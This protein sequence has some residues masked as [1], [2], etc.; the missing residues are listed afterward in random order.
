MQESLLEAVS[1]GRKQEES[2]KKVADVALLWQRS[3]T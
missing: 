1:T 3:I 2:D